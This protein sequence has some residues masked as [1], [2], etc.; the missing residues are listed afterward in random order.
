MIGGLSSIRYMREMRRRG[1]LLPPREQM[2]R[3]DSGHGSALVLAR[4][5]AAALL[6]TGIACESRSNDVDDVAGPALE[7]MADEIG[8]PIMRNLA[9]GHVGG[10]SGEIVLV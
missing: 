2:S 6:L 3:R 9:R 4:T 8:A 7:Q 1:R 10:V 5:V